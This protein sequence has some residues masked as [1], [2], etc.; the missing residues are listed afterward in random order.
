M[1]FKIKTLETIRP[2]LLAGIC[3]VVLCA[4]FS[5]YAQDTAPA[6]PAPVLDIDTA[7]ALPAVV[8][9]VEGEAISGVEYGK[10]LDGLKQRR[11]MMSGMD[12]NRD[13]N[14]PPAGV[15]EEEKRTLLDN[16]IK[17]KVMAC[18][19]RKEELAATDEEVQEAINEIVEKNPQIQNEEQ[20]ATMVEAQG[21]TLDDL[22]ARIRDSLITEK[23]FEMKTKDII[24]TD[25]DTTIKYDE[26]KEAGQLNK[27]AMADVSHILASPVTAEPG[28]NQAEAAEKATE[29]E[30]AAAKERID[31]ARARIVA[32]E[33]FAKVAEEVTDDPGSKANGG[34]YPNT[35]K[36]K[37]VPAFDKLTFEGPIGE[38]SEPFK[39]SFGWHIL[40]VKD[41][42]EA[43]V[44][45]FDEVK[46]RIIEFLE[47]QE[48]VDAFT[49]YVDEAQ[50]GLKIEILISF[51][52]SGAEESSGDSAEGPA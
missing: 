26:L 22:K 23:L 48:K 6:A 50:K 44:A 8:A 25:E 46:D 12:P 47:R 1:L 17:T 28:V 45:E 30:W 16:M 29:E 31:A 39:T 35:V 49:K 3:A 33:D 43:G 13:P 2:L 24:V 38:L 7:P 10:V 27:P 36:G 20:F 4:S 41:R 32:G 9:T 21:M 42:H 51:A 34:M 5:A 14:Q 40:I 52:D 18:L 15:T 37:M 19:A 11:A